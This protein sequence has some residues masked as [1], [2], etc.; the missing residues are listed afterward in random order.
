MCRVFGKTESRPGAPR[1]GLRW[2]R[3]DLN[4]IPS[5]ASGRSKCIHYLFS[6]LGI[7]EKKMINDPSILT[8]INLI[9]MCKTIQETEIMVFHFQMKELSPEE[10]KRWQMGI[11]SRVCLTRPCSAGFLGRRV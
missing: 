3:Q 5:E 6:L 10:S 2:A 1:M 4:N 11:R 9:V 8:F 7:C